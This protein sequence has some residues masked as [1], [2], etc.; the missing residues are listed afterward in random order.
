[1][2]IRIFNLAGEL[3][4]VLEEKYGN[5]MVSWDGRNEQGNLVVIGI[6][7]FVMENFSGKI[8]IKK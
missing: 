7:I 1:M 4:K 8:A 5:N 6:Y 3:V 2:K